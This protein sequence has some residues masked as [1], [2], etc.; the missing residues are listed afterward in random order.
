[1]LNYSSITNIQATIIIILI[2]NF[3]KIYDMVIM[4]IVH[5]IPLAHTTH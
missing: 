4:K 1:M 5:M 2:K 3:H